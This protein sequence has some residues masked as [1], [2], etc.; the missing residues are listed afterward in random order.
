TMKSN[1]PKGRSLADVVQ[2]RAMFMGMDP[3]AL[4][5]AATRFFNRIVDMPLDH[6]SYLAMGEELGVGTMDLR[7]LGVEQVKF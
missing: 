2:T 3:V 6:V 4:D 7:S 1:G 5:T